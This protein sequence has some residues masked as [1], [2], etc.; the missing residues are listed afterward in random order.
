ML[1]TELVI[2]HDYRRLSVRLTYKPSGLFS[3]LYEF[4]Y[5]ISYKKEIIDMTIVEDSRRVLKAMY[6]LITE[7]SYACC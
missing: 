2:E 4:I 7:D 5:E 3:N 6:N 1:I